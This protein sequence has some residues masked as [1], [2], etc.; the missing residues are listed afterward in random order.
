[1]VTELLYQ[2]FFKGNVR[3]NGQDV[4]PTFN[5]TDI[6]TAV[7]SVSV[8]QDQL[9]TRGDYLFTLVLDGTPTSRDV[10]IQQLFN[11]WTTHTQYSKYCIV[12]CIYSKQITE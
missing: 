12:L 10:V 11:A 8:Y 2:V 3:I 7:S 9:P 6:E 5:S 4:A 1:M